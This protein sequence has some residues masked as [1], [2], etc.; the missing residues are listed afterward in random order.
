MTVIATSDGQTAEIEP[1]PALATAG[2]GDVLSG[3]IAAFLAQGLSPF[4][5][6][7]LAAFVGARAATRVSGRYGTLG[8][9]ASDLPAA[10]AEEL[11]SL[12]GMDS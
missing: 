5:A 9:L 7:K 2:T 11:A 10:I 3:A 8:V 4:D 1:S 6:G 12:E